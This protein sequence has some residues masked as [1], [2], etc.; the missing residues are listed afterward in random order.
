MNK[1]VII[2]SPRSQKDSAL[3]PDNVKKTAHPVQI[4]MLTLFESA[5]K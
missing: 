4:Y 3:Y 2:Y 1:S 5:V